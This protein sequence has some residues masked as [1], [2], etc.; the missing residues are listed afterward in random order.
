MVG[1]RVYLQD[2]ANAANYQDWLVASVT[3]FSTY[4]RVTVSLVGSGGTGTTNFANNLDLAV[5]LLRTGSQGPATASGIEDASNVSFTWTDGTR[6]LAVAPVSGSYTYWWH[7]LKHSV[8]GSQNVVITNT[9]GIHFV[10]FNSLTGVLTQSTTAWDILSDVAVAAVY[11]NATTSKG[12]LLN[13]K[14]GLVMDPATHLRLHTVDGTRVVSG[15]G[16]SGTTVSPS[17]PADADNDIQVATGVIADEDLRVTVPA[18]GNSASSYRVWY[19][20]GASGDWT[21]DNTSLPFTNAASSYMHFNE[22]TGGTWQKTALTNSQYMNMWVCATPALNDNHGIIF[23]MGQAVYPTLAGA[24]AEDIAVAVNWG[25]LPFPEIAAL[26]KVT[27]RTGSA[28]TSTGKCR[29]DVAPVSIMNSKLTIAV[30]G[31]STLPSA[32]VTVNTA[33]FNGLLTASETNV[34][35]ALE[36]LDDVILEPKPYWG[37]LA[38]T[39]STALTSATGTYVAVWE[40]LTDDSLGVAQNFTSAT[41]GMICPVDGVYDVTAVLQFTK[42]TV[43]RASVRVMRNGSA[44]TGS[45][46]LLPD[47][48]GNTQTIQSA[49]SVPCLATDKLSLNALTFGSDMTITA[50][51][52]IVSGPA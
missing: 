44:V 30:A 14:H 46:V 2:A 28:Y 37:R 6:T 39:T 41:D 9:T 45:T 51:Y 22:F 34:Q 47:Q 50:L 19:R 24:Q 38:R 3:M 11:W 33:N 12:V 18:Q 25:V 5:S 1:D 10:Y 40:T 26:Y 20:T 36:K 29:I 23:V 17:S 42:G 35:L 52:L 32:S 49:I 7:G 13:E 43:G 4:G 21:W 15:F 48:T 31:A 8:S 27:F 16:F